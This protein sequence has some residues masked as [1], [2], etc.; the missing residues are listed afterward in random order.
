MVTNVH[1]LRVVSCVVTASELAR[2]LCEPSIVLEQ[3]LA[4]SRL[5]DQAHVAA[6]AAARTELA[7]HQAQALARG[8]PAERPT[9]I[10]LLRQLQTSRPAEP[11]CALLAVGWR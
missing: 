6:D 8:G 2:R 4:I 5:L 9:A 11:E 1:A 3:V 10:E 7:L